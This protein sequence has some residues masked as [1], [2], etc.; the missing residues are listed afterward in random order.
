MRRHAKADGFQTCSS[1]E[2]STLIETMI[3]IAIILICAVGVLALASTAL[4]TTENQGHLIARTAEYSQ[5]KM[6]QLLALKY[7]DYT[8]DTTQIPTKTSG[9][10]GLAGCPA[11]DVNNAT[12]SE[13][14]GG[15]SNPSTTVTG[16]VDYLDNSG[17]PVTG[18]GGAAPATWAYIR[19]WQIKIAPSNYTKQITVTTQVRAQVGKIGEPPKATVTVLKTYPF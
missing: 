7:C 17:T 12:L 10:T 9:G 19:V 13:G 5:D 4:M 1:Q 3:A 14:N 16:Y 15:S 2:G 8:S 11:F 18:P 6:E